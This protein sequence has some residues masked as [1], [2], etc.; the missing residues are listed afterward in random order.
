MKYKIIIKKVVIIISLFV[1][2]IKML[3]THSWRPIF[4]SVHCWSILLVFSFT[5]SPSELSTT[6]HCFCELSKMESSEEEDDFPSI[7]SIIPQSKVDSLYQSQTEK[8]RFF[9]FHFTIINYQCLLTMFFHFSFLI[10]NF[11]FCISKEK[12][13]KWVIFIFIIFLFGNSDLLC[14]CSIK[15]T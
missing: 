15:K 2:T 9:L 7:E 14:W 4:Q 1:Y 8:V 5:S 10:F 6:T 12:R 13:E 3:T 11:F